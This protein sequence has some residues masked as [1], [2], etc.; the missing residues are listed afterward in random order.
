MRADRGIGWSLSGFEL[1]GTDP[2]GVV[3]LV[4][5]VE[6]WDDMAGATGGVI[7]KDYDD[8]GRMQ[9]VFL[10]PPS[11][12]LKVRILAPT[13][14]KLLAAKAAMQ[15]AVPVRTP[16]PLVQSEGG[17]LKHRRV[18]QEGRPSFKRIN[19]F[20]IDASVQLVAPDTRIF[21]GAGVPWYSYTAEAR[22]PVTTGGLQVGALQV[23]AGT[24]LQV[25]ANTVSGSITLTNAGN[26]E[27]PVKLLITNA[28]NP[29]ISDQAGQR[30]DLAIT[31]GAGQTLEVDLDRKTVKLNGVN[32]RN[33]LNGPWLVPAAGAVLQ[34]NAKTYNAAAR[35]VAQ[36][37][38]AWR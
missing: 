33:A 7:P 38:D 25:T 35:M 5:D 26:A 36:W 21:S 9:P 3:W 27:P 19:E 6:G 34:F 11:L 2:D 18:L 31:V 16:A 28:V 29:S 12:V 37:S 1:S 15:A 8:G 30:M 23:G 17:R 4:Q 24:P 10:E 14:E 20:I 22:L 13:T 32:R